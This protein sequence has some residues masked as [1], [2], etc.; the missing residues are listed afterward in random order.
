[1]SAADTIEVRAIVTMTTS[2]LQ[3]IVANAKALV[4]PDARG[5][6]RVDT[7][8]LVSHMVSRFLLERDF[9]AYVKDIDN[10]PKLTPETMQ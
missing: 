1:M 7:A 8:D 2:A 3:T 10:Y 4:G 9:E 5:H 6:Y